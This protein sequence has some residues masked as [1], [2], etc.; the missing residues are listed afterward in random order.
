MSRK[1]DATPEEYEKSVNLS[2][3][4]LE[5]AIDASLHLLCLL[6]KEICGV[7]YSVPYYDGTDA[8]KI[9][10]HAYKH[11]L[12]STGEPA[13]PEWAALLA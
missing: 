8:T 12:L 5:R 3:G 6:Y 2:W 13:S 11:D 4:E 9:A 1:K 7:E 10:E